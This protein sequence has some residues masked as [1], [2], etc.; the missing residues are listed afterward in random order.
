MSKAQALKSFKTELHISHSQ[1]FSYLACPLKY[2]FSYVEERQPE[3]IGI[4]LPFGSAI[5]KAVEKFWCGVRDGAKEPFSV[6]E[7]IFATSLLLEME[8]D[9]PVIFKKDMPDFDSAASMGASM[10]KAFHESINTDGFEVVDVEAALTARLYNELG[11]PTDFNLVGVIDLILLDENGVL[12]AV[13]TKTSSKSYSQVN[14]DCDGQLS[15]YAYLLVANRYVSRLDEVS[16]RFDV[17]RKLKK[18]P[19]LEHYTTTR[20]PQDRRRFSKL[21]CAV[22]EAVSSGAFY[23]NRG[24]MCGDCQH[25]KACAEW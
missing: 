4:A 18:S 17:L 24:W 1:V 3:R 22:L 2:R 23:P 6:L 9:C 25:S 11:S 12:W 7:D 16:C 14:V 8:R 15:A 5:H 19:S 10:L 13:D 21:V 20:S